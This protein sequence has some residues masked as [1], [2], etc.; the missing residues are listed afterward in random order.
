MAPVPSASSPDPS[1]LLTEAELELMHV[2]WQRG[3]S[4]VREV[5]AALPDSRAYTTI[6]TILRILDDKGFAASEKVGRAFRY[7]ASVD[8]EAYQARNVRHVVDAV[9]KGDPVALVRRLVDAEDL[10]AD[11]LSA[12]RA[13]VEELSP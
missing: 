2:L 1:R 7:T 3:P 5:M 4:T 9:F 12:L 8:R 13:L 11:E 6:S 10:D